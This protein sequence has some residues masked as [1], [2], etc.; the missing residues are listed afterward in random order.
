VSLTSGGKSRRHPPVLNCW[1]GIEKLWSFKI[2]KGSRIARIFDNC[3]ILFVHND[4]EY[5]NGHEEELVIAYEDENV[6]NE[7]KNHVE[8]LK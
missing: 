4:D 7:F 6:V 5:G 3:R 1:K 8:F 2:P